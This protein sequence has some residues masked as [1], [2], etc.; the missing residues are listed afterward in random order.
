MTLWCINTVAL[1]GCKPR[2]SSGGPVWCLVWCSVPEDGEVLALGC[3]DQTLSFYELSGEGNESQSQ[4]ILVPIRP[5]VLLLDYSSVDIK[6]WTHE[7][8]SGAV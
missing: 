7:I 6:I 3:W 8:V 5:R 4:S 2:G 1:D